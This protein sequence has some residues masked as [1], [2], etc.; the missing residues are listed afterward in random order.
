MGGLMSREQFWDALTMRGWSRYFES[1]P[2]GTLAI[3]AILICFWALLGYKAL[4]GDSDSKEKRIVARAVLIAGFFALMSC[5]FAGYTSWHPQWTLTVLHQAS[6][7]ALSPYG[8]TLIL[9]SM[10][11]IAIL[12]LVGLI[13]IVIGAVLIQLQSPQRGK[14]CSRLLLHIMP[15]SKDSVSADDRGVS[16]FLQ[17][18]SSSG[19]VR[20][21]GERWPPDQPRNIAGISVYISADGRK[22]YS[23]RPKGAR[24]LVRLNYRQPGLYTAL[25][26]VEKDRYGQDRLTL[27][28]SDDSRRKRIG[29]SRHLEDSQVFKVGD[30]WFMLCKE[31]ER[32]E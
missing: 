15:E 29:S 2:A 13:A 24:K 11:A 23:V 1:W 4:P 6:L 22:V 25:G 16:W 18:V 14:L 21:N 30:S 9:D 10:R 19:T 3:V 26:L 27:I 8:I 5:C 20:F 28:A 31:Q 17:L 32:E 7:Y 12:E